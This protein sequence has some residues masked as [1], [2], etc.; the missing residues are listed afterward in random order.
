MPVNFKPQ[1][2]V[3]WFLNAVSFRAA[4]TTTA[5]ACSYFFKYIYLFQPISTFSADVPA[6]SIRTQFKASLIKTRH[7]LIH[8]VEQIVGVCARLVIQ[9]VGAES[10]S[11][12]NQDQK[13]QDLWVYR[14]DKY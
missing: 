1:Q 2:S 5:D 8:K 12:I 11:E 10:V 4:N 13:S 6:V 14:S 3:T 7:A 9:S